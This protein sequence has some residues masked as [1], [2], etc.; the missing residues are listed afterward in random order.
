[1]ASSLIPFAVAAT[2]AALILGSLEAGF[3]IGRRLPRAEA[4]DERSNIGAIQAA[5]L[6]LLGLLLGFSFAGASGRFVDRQNLITQESNAI[7]TAFLRADL[8]APPASDDLRAALRD[9]AAERLY[10]L[11][12][13]PEFLESAEQP[14]RAA[15]LHDRI[16]RAALAGVSASPALTVPVLGPVNEVLDLHASHLA[17]QRKHLPGLVLGALV[18]CAVCTLGLVGFGC[19]LSGKRSLMLTGTFAFLVWVT[20]WLTIDLDYPRRGLVRVDAEA[21]RAL[22]DSMGR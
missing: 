16:W 18:V 17:A 2:L 13:H 9:Y 19:G 3:R 11:G 21:M 1:M 20:L 4:K 22:V 8:L 15:A 7:G 14:A 12:P 10:W 6:G 5:T